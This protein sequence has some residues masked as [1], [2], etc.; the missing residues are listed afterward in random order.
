MADTAH[1]DPTFMTEH[2]ED[3]KTLN[4]KTDKLVELIKKSK[5]FVVFTG[6]GISTSAG[7]PDFRGPEGAWTLA[8]QGK[9]RTSPTV[10]VLK[11]IPT[12]THM[13]LVDLQNKGKF[14]K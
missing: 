3:E 12:S 1:K 8:A 7:I 6:A 10:D 14:I 4:K 9:R 11:A 5:H 2:F 13:S